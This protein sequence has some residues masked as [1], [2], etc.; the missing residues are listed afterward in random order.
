LRELLLPSMTDCPA[1]SRGRTLEAALREAIRAGRLP[2]RSRL[3]SSRDLATQ[4][5][6]ARGTVTASYRQLA[7]EGYLVARR[8]SGTTVADALHTST[9]PPKPASIPDRWRFDLRPGLPALGAFPRAAWVAATRAGLASLPDDA[10]GYP[11]AAGLAELRAELA[12]YLGRV[13]AVVVA[14]EDLIITHGVAEGLSLLT[15]VLHARGHRQIAVE[16]PGSPGGADLFAAHGLRPVP[17]TVDDRGLRVDQ[18]A[19]SGCRAVL[20]TSAHQFPLGMVLHPERRRTL[21]NWAR[22]NDGLVIEDDYDAE[23]RYDRPALGAVQALDPT[24]VVYQGSVSKV[25]A[26]ALRIGWLLAPPAL[27]SDLVDAKHFH[28]LG[29]SPLPQAALAHLIRTGTYER[30]LRRTRALHRQRR[31]A[32][33]TAVSEHL[34]RCSPVG[35][36]AGL[37]VVLRFPSGTDDLA[38]QRALAAR[39]VNAPAL[40]GYLPAGGAAPFPGLVLG[41]AWMSPDRL[42]SAV[43][44]IADVLS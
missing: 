42:R 12:G 27:R 3:P 38:L 25:L 22:E 41:Y 35:V 5:G 14:P 1:R 18:L 20:V 11:E 16:N 7:A 21:L 39:G 28:D 4:L 17:I 29:C 37:H 13:R 36:A 26:P 8:G 23:H 32:L 33:L 6:M 44:I 40:S 34:P 19:A 2:T 30:H 10:L 43:E 24:R 15:Q 31:D 9:R